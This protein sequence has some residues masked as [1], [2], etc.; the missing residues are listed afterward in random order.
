M[1]C[2]VACF[3]CYSLNLWFP[4]AISVRKYQRA[5]QSPSV[6]AAQDNHAIIPRVLMPNVTGD[7]LSCSLLSY[8]LNSVYAI[9]SVTSHILLHEGGILYQSDP[10]SSVNLQ[11]CIYTHSLYQFVLLCSYDGPCFFEKVCSFKSSL[12]AVCR[13]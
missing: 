7:I 11:Q 5:G 3:F 10:W 2:S 9:Q 13:C 6:C 4:P 12:S 1:F 8:A